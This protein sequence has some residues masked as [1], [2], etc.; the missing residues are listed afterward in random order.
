MYS[1]GGKGNE[2]FVYII[3]QLS[4]LEGNPK[5]PGELFMLASAASDL[6]RFGDQLLMPSQH[7]DHNAGTIVCHTIFGVHSW[8][9]MRLYG[10]DGPLTFQYRDSSA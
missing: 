1:V 3:G 4:V 2:G 8:A 10:M 5:S 9:F 6:N 7:S